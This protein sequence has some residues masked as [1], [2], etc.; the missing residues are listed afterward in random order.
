MT[1]R[2]A[3]QRDRPISGGP[4]S[5]PPPKPR[6]IASRGRREQTVARRSVPSGTRTRGG[7]RAGTRGV[8]PFARGDWSSGRGCWERPGLAG[9]WG[10][11]C[12]WSPSR[13]AEPAAGSWRPLRRGLGATFPSGSQPAARALVGPARRNGAAG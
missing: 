4:V 1:V 3:N 6:P 12:A 2:A 10:L 8:G 13:H 9:R 5:G 7:Q 11:T